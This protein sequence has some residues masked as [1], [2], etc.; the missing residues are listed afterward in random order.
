MPLIPFS[1]NTVDYELDE[2][3]PLKPS[4][5]HI[6]GTDEEGRDIFARIL[7][8][9]RISFLFSFLFVG[10]GNFLSLE[11]WVSLCSTI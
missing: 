11:L 9:I 7:Y 3:F 8:G 6:L 10:K 2:P 4:S 1:Y 5:R